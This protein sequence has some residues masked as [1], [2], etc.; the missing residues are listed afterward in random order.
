[1]FGVGLIHNV[2]TINLWDRSL[3]SINII[4]LACEIRVEILLEEYEIL[5]DSVADE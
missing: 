3:L 5:I 1:M 2:G 4:T